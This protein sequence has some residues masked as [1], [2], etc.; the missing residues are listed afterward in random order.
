M[1]GLATRQSDRDHIRVFAN[2]EIL[3]IFG[4]EKEDHYVQKVGEDDYNFS[5]LRQVLRLLKKG[6]PGSIELLY[7]TQWIE[8]SEVW[9]FAI[10]HR[11]NLLNSEGY[12]SALRGYAQAEIK[13]AKQVNTGKLGAA[14]KKV[15]TEFGFSPK[16]YVNALRLLNQGAQFFRDGEL[17]VNLF[18]SNYPLASQLLELKTCP[19]NFKQNDLNL[20]VADA[21]KALVRAYEHRLFRTQFLNSIAEQICLMAYG[22]TISSRFNVFSP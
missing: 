2:T 15:L 22:E 7:N 18:L 16:N 19:A 4:L 11:D 9:G 8:K 20:M 13:A 10:Q 14:R 5:E 1:Y 12:F 21:E 3:Q 6:N 17:K